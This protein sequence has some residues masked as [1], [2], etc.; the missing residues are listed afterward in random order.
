MRA[1]QH[2]ILFQPLAIGPKLARNRFYQV[3]HCNGMGYREPAMLAAMR[4]MKAEGGWAVVCTEEVEIH[5]SSEV[6]PAIEGRIWDD[7]DIGYHQRVTEAIHEH[8]ALA[9][10]ELVYNAPRTNLVSRLPAMGVGQMPVAAEWLEPTQSRAMDKADIADLRRWHRKAALRAKAAGYDL[11]YVYAGHG[12]TLTQ[13]FLSRAF[14]QRSDEYGGSLENRVR[15]IRELLEE[16]REAVGDTCAVPFRMAVEESLTGGLER[17]EIEDVVGMLAELPDLWDFCMGSWSADSRTSRFAGEGFQEQFVTGLKA[18]TSKPVVGVGRFTSVDEM[19]RQIRTGVLDFVGAARPSIA[20]PFLPKKIEQGRYDDIRECIGCNICVAGDMQS[21]PLRCTQNPTMGEEWRRGWH[22]EAIAAAHVR[23]KILVVGAGPAG[24]EAALQLGRR[25][26]EV[27][28]ADS[29]PLLGGR[30][31]KEAALPGLSA[32]RRVVDWRL[33]QIC[34][35]PNVS[36]Y[37]ASTMTVADILELGVAHV[38][39]A[40]GATYRRDGIGRHHR[41]PIAM[42]DSA[43]VLTPDDVFA[44]ASV[45]GSLLVYDDDHYVL[46]AAIAEKYAR[47]GCNVTLATPAPLVSFWTQ[48]TLEQGAVEA[49]LVECGVRIA[50][51]TKLAGVNADSVALI[52]DVTGASRVHGCNATV[53]CSSRLATTGLFDDLTDRR[54]D[55]ADAGIASVVTIGDAHAP[56]MIVH[57]VHSGHRYAREL[58]ETVDRDSVPFARVT[59]S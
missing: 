44:G 11:I 48:M 46:G 36:L 53:L 10:I 25:G 54:E 18:L 56:A 5:P 26:H 20:D 16:T 7:R 34:K 32:W 17:A 42:S 12:L 38:A 19:V 58:G 41:A 2:D 50:T 27:M 21:V 57:A 47:A 31:L 43:R 45:Q 22:P 59:A 39:L 24:L 15:L 35:L 40:T 29:A 49:R 9:G 3:P 55:W 52:D 33:G 4:G 6:S 14:N 1:R 28:L 30:V 23:E 51:R 13:Q 37:P 8:G